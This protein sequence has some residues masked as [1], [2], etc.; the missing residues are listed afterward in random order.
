MKQ[1]LD[2][3]ES[4]ICLSDIWTTCK[5]AKGMI[6]LGALLTAS[7]VC[8]FTLSKPV[9]YK[10]T[11]TFREKSSSPLPLNSSI[12][13]LIKFENAGE[14]SNTPYL[15]LSQ[16]ILSP[17]IKKLHLQASLDEVESIKTPWKNAQENLQVLFAYLR[18]K[19]N[20][21]LIIPDIE[22]KISCHSIY[23]DSEF[24][25]R[26][27][28]TFTSNDDFTIKAL[29][30]KSLGKGK[31]DQPFKGENF[32]FTISHSFPSISQPLKPHFLTLHPQES[33]EKSLISMI[34]IAPSSTA[35]NILELS[36][37]HKDRQFAALLLNHLMWEY[38][39]F[40]K[41][42][43]QRKA[44]EQLV[45]LENRKNEMSQKLEQLMGEHREYLEENI[46][47]GG[48]TQMND[49]SSFLANAQNTWQDKLLNLDM[50]LHLIN[51]GQINPNFLAKDKLYDPDEN[52][53]TFIQNLL[54]RIRDLTLQKDILSTHLASS[55]LDHLA[56][57]SPD[58]PL[59]KQTNAEMALESVE[60]RITNLK[61]HLN[62]YLSSRRDSVLHHKILIQEQI[63]ELKQQMSSLPEKWFLE[64]RMKLHMMIS[65]NT[66]ENVSSLVEGT[67]IAHRLESIE[68]TPLNLAI[69]PS[70]P[71]IS[72]AFIFTILAALFGAVTTA[73]FL[74]TKS[75]SRGFPVSLDNLIQS[76]QAVAG[77]LS[78]SC[79]KKSSIEQLPLKDLETIRNIITYITMD[80]KP[81]KRIS[82]LSSFGPN[83]SHSLTTL[84][85][86]KEDRVLILSCPIN[87]P[88]HI[89]KE[90]GLIHYLEKLVDNLHIQQISADYDYVC[91]GGTSPYSSELLASKR[92]HSLL[93][94]LEKTYSLIIF[95][96]PSAISSP[97]AK[98]LFSLADLSVISL[99]EENINDLKIFIENDQK[100][101]IFLF[102]KKNIA[103]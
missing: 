47:H 80:Q 71:E 50:E 57:A 54:Q 13:N 32:Q 6:F 51:N 88:L 23:F 35:P 40:L 82:L 76:Q 27:L 38:Q 99:I 8:Y 53:N 98:N 28:I 97:E 45:Y 7:L 4:F 37:T 42:E 12:Q 86:K 48:F 14:N 55:S 17:L 39:F 31:I 11:A 60:K 20:K 85:S 78:L 87:A 1:I 29:G 41:S 92:F 25:L 22:Q 66:I 70:S 21:A 58:F 52:K 89:Q 44:K 69:P 75:F 93:N 84:L 46:R 74:V 94:T 5:R 67:I 91:S 90:S 96:C 83:Y 102:T 26:L 49:L 101:P 73:S 100:K 3:K 16:K 30:N 33:L 9:S 65:E 24:P 36:L 81:I 18:G 63:Q 19:I 61:Q 64:E 56:S 62:N 103:P 2:E 95:H 15:M 72:K 59:Q 43:S 34:D 10:V 79:H 68:S 77:I